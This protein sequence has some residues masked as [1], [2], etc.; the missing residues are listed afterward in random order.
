MDQTSLSTAPPEPRRVSSRGRRAPYERA[1]DERINWKASIPFFL[2]HVLA[3]TMPFVVGVTWKAF[4]LFVVMVWGRVW[5]ITAGYHRYFA[6]RAYKT[7]RPFQLF[8]AVGGATCAQKGPLWWAG[9]HREHHRNSD[10]EADIHSPLRGF[11]WSHMGWI[12]CDKYDEIPHERIKD[13]SKYPELRFVD[14]WNGLFPWAAAI[15]CTIIAGWSGLFVGFFLGTVVLWHN[16]FLVNSL[17]HVMGRRRFVTEDTSRNSA[18]I[19]ITTLG[20]GWHNNHHYYQASARNGFMWWEIDVTYYGLKALSWFGLVRDLKVPTAEMLAANRV[21]D[22]NFDIGTFKAHW[23]RA[24][25]A[26]SLTHAQL[27][28]RVAD[29]RAHAAEALAERRESLHERREALD[30]AI[31]ARK[32]ALDEFVH[33]SMASAEEL[34]RV[35]RRGNRELGLLDS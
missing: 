16:T 31:E 29:S 7:S 8:L 24:Q 10:T 22:G 19:A 9:H 1:A 30:H 12:L 14:K 18:L 32:Q 13:F 27:G 5:F 20:E 34:A 17:A 15:A 35:T 6:H 2:V 21:A 25:A 33:G 23:T 26:V 11:W 3:F 4:F 28:A